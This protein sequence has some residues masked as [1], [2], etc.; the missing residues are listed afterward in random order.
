MAISRFGAYQNCLAKT[1]QEIDK[2]PSVALL[3]LFDVSFI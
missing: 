1:C 2:R 3:Q